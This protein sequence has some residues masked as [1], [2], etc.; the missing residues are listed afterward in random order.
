MS[1]AGARRRE[2]IA[3]VGM[4]GRFPGAADI[5]ALWRVLV[6]GRETIRFFAPHELSSEV[7]AAL[8]LRS[9]YVPARG[10]LD[11]AFDFD[12]DFFRMT[13]REAELT[14]PQQ[15][16]L[17]ELA[18]HALEDAGIDPRRPPG[19][20]GV[21][22]GKGPAEYVLHN[23]REH[24][25]LLERF[26]EFPS[27]IATEKDYVATRIA[28]ELDLRG[29]AISI[30][31][32]CSTALLAVSLAMDA[33]RLGR[34][35]VA[36]AGAACVQSPQE[37]GYLAIEGSHA[38]DDG[39]VRPF[40]ARAT[41]TVFS[42][43]LGMVVLK[44]LEDAQRDGDAIRAVLLGIGMNNNG[45]A[46]A[47]FM[48][49]GAEGQAGAVRQALEDAGV[50]AGTLSFVEAHG[51]AT[52]EGDPIEVAGLSS[53]FARGRR[54]AGSCLLGSMKG[55]IGHLDAAAG[56][57]SLIKTVLALE[58]GVVPGTLHFAQANPRIDFANS[59]F[60]VTAEA[61][62]WPRGEQ[63]RR[64][65]VSAFG[66]G[67]TNVHLVLEEAP[68]RQAPAAG[69]AR[70]LQ[71]VLLSA[72]SAGA[73]DAGAAALAGSLHASS[74]AGTPPSLPDVAH[75]LQVG[76]MQHAL[77]RFVVAGDVPE[78]LAALEAPSSGHLVTGTAPA[79]P[80]RVAFVFP[81][82]GAQ[83]L[84][85]G[86][87]LHRCEPEFRRWFD[88]CSERLAR[89]LGEDPRA[90]LFAKDASAER[91]AETR[92]TQPLVFAIEYALARLWQSWGLQPDALVGH[93]V[94][95]FAAACLAGVFSL[96]DA[97]HLV[98]LRGRLMQQLPGGSMLAVRLSE[99][100]LRATLPDGVSVA[101]VNG[102]QSCVASG[103]SP[104]IAALDELLAARGV[105]RQRLATSHAFHS[106]AMTPL[107][108][109]FE[110]EVA[111]VGLSAPSL[112]LLSTRDGAPLSAALATDPAYWA[113][114]VIE[115]VR[116]S[117]AVA[118]LWRAEQRFVLEVGPGRALTGMCRQQ[119][120]VPATQ[121]AVASLTETPPGVSEYRSLLEALG[122]AWLA[123]V[124]ID[125]QA[126]AAAE[127]RRRL[128]L[129]GYAFQRRRY[130]LP[131][132]PAAN[133]TTRAALPAGAPAPL[134]LESAATL[135]A[136]RVPA[137][138]RQ[139]TVAAAPFPARATPAPA[140]GARLPGLAASAPPP[141]RTDLAD[142]APVGSS[143]PAGM[144]ALPSARPL[145]EPQLA[146]AAFGGTAPQ[147]APL[148]AAPT[149]AP[150]PAQGPLAMASRRLTHQQWL[151]ALRLSLEKASGGSLAHAAPTTSF[152]ELGFDSLFLTQWSRVLRDETGVVVRVRQLIETQNTF[153]ALAS[154]LVAQAQAVAPPVA[155][156]SIE[157]PV[158][159]AMPAPV[160]PAG[161]AA[162]A[163]R[164]PAPA[165]LPASE[166][167]RFTQQLEALQRQLL[168]LRGA[169]AAQQSATG[170]ASP[171]PPSTQPL[172]PAPASSSTPPV[173][174]AR[175][176]R[177]AS[178]RPAWFVPDPARPGRYLQ[179][180]RRA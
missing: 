176:G 75:T 128:L 26:G 102:P 60:R 29:P 1:S 67:G 71:L 15:R 108:P 168:S 141:A 8:R 118:T 167:E 106:A 144:A 132:V 21:F 146:V 124:P 10:V 151:D 34:C 49:A 12:A 123:G 20:I 66:I 170:A 114:H 82:Q 150:A 24:R 126:F 74:A 180:E 69:S 16:L 93:S 112:P 55:N 18:L 134:A 169:A 6:E 163:P 84:H 103:P 40:D 111:R 107:L 142:A 56:I 158:P 78:L 23:L 97:L 50:D 46:P 35:D 159:P 68:L 105:A 9:D 145:V 171:Q 120:R 88:H 172:A 5:E 173:P 143:V 28:Y 104:A 41:G 110:A 86:A 95:Q 33:L 137:P 25:D 42:S 153:E 43:G 62:P 155:P 164:T 174:G 125:W 130:Y 100:E 135:P 113:A 138:Q 61:T 92:F 36:L 152:L 65:G 77:R 162:S 2:P 27:K 85:M 98:A 117:D 32:A 131:G 149:G 160:A 37:K 70:P 127:T 177:D 53:A 81:G 90:L 121:A 63:P 48:G 45:S 91:L 179:V 139:P 116:F 154:Y 22:A 79:A 80:P 58:R 101:A 148:G 44:R 54:P 76:R 175:L 52:M 11:G 3:I 129:P 7:P 83:Y 30:N 4:A 31:T 89:S 73:L 57:A 156:V 147:P 109:A 17:L 64:A 157:P 122:R 59:P 115:P 178:G 140:A 72:R 99:A 96:D 47:S 38:S 161:G 87:D 94:G 51:T 119:L 165:A 19:A 136:G 14:D 39:H 166:L 13:P 133:T